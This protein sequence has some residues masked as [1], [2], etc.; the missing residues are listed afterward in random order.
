MAESWNRLVKGSVVS[1]GDFQP[2]IFP[3]GSDFQLSWMNEYGA[4]PGTTN[5]PK[6]SLA[7]TGLGLIK[8]YS[9]GGG[10]EP[11]ATVLR[12]VTIVSEGVLFR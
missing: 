5:Y 8:Y 4:K 11:E 2:T 7:A 3:H 6:I 9:I 1:H 12:K 10:H